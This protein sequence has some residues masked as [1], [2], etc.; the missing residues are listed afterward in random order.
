VRALHNAEDMSFAAKISARWIR[1]L[2]QFDEHL[3]TMHGLANFNRRNENISAET[4]ANF[5]LRRSHEPVAVAMHVE[6]SD[7]E[8]AIGGL[9]RKRILVAPSEHEFA[10]HDK[11]GKLTLELST[12]VSAEREFADELLVRGRSVRQA[13]DVAQQLRLRDH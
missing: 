6:T 11:I 7:D 8:V 12:I 5:F 9:R 2:A 13:F 10:A 1:A 3:I 4:F